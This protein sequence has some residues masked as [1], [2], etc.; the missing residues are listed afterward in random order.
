MHF[1]CRDFDPGAVSGLVDKAWLDQWSTERNCLKSKERGDGGYY[2]PKP[3]PKKREPR[4]WYE[5][6]CQTIAL[7]AHDAMKERMI[8]FATE[9]ENELS[10]FGRILATG[11]TGR[12]VEAATRKLGG[13]I[14]RCRSGPKGGDVEIAT[15]ILYGRCDVVIFFIDPLHPHPHIEDIRVVFGA[16]MTE[17]EVR[18]L[19][20]EVQARKWMDEVVRPRIA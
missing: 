1:S 6:G 15:E 17:D 13:K 16:C 7:I 9:Y 2:I 14:F 20:N 4:F 5:F 19:T 11:T 12:E 10:A 18:M 3:I 8:E